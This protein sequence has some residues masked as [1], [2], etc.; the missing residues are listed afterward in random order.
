[1]ATLAPCLANRRAVAK[2]IPRGLAAPET[3][4]VLPVSSICFPPIFFGRFPPDWP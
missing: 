2:P 4:A 3:A 1:M